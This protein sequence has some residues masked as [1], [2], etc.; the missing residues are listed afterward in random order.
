MKKYIFISIGIILVIAVVCVFYFMGQGPDIARFE[1]LK[2]PQFSNKA[3]LKVMEVKAVG[4]P[5]VVTKEAYKVLFST[6]FKTK[7][8]PKHPIPAPLARWIGDLTTPMDKWE[9]HFAIS[10][11]ENITSAADIK[12]KSGLKVEINTWEYGEVEEILHIGP[13][14]TEMP[15]I[16]KLK[17]FIKDNGYEIAGPHEEEYLKGPGMFWP[18]SPKKYATIIRYQVKKVSK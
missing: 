12:D 10:I 6:Y 5:E 8:V 2:S 17:N 14:D 13:Y 18:T 3:S 1:Y 11:P 7:G 16:D 15:T 4:S 9:G